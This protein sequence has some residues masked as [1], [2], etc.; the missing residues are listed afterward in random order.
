M[1]PIFMLGLFP[2]WP[3]IRLEKSIS[4]TLRWIMTTSACVGLGAT[5][6]FA[7]RQHMG[8]IWG[9]GELFFSLGA[10]TAAAMAL[11]PLS[12]SGLAAPSRHKPQ[13][14]FGF[15]YLLLF[16]IVSTFLDTGDDIIA[17][18]KRAAQVP[19]TWVVLGV[20]GLFALHAVRTARWAV[21]AVT[22]IILT[23]L[24]G[25]I[26]GTAASSAVPWLM[27]LHLL[28]LGITLIVLEFTGRRGAPRLGAAL[29]SAL[30][31][32]R[33]F[34]SDLSLL[35]KGLAFIVIGTAFLAFNITMSRLKTRYTTSQL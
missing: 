3:G 18:Y 11:F 30:L 32:A 17:S 20:T 33:M 19:W 12:S 15:L 22:S 24:I 16:A 8:R 29:L 35:L 4:V 27:T 6:Y 21:L 25:L 2:F 10:F 1:Y 9:D 28:I 34:E 7:A 23:P 14:I 5:A 26:F 31:I 13:V